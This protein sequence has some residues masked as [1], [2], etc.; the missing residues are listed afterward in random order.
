MGV[1]TIVSALVLGLSGCTSMMIG[2]CALPTVLGLSGAILTTI[3]SSIIDGAYEDNL[4]AS[5]E[6]TIF[7]LGIGS[8]AGLL[9]CRA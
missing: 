1:I 4:I 7:F 3:G 6:Q 8:I 5:V 9:L 2:T